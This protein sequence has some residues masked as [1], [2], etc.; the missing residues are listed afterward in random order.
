MIGNAKTFVGTC[1]RFDAESARNSQFSIRCTAGRLQNE[2]DD[3]RRQRN[4]EGLAAKKTK[5]SEDQSETPTQN[6][7]P[8]QGSDIYRF[9]NKLLN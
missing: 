9:M 3:A 1:S 6:Q 4:A 5:G 7:I 2:K 8:N